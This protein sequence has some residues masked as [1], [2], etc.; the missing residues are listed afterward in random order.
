MWNFIEKIVYWF[1]NI[2]CKLAKKELTS[3]MLESMMQFAK[4][5][6][7]GISNTLLSYVIN[8]LVLIAMK[9]IDVSWDYFVGNIIAFIISVLWSF[10]WNNRFV[11]TVKEGETRSIWR[12]LL[13][14]Y[15]AY[16]F[17]GIVLSNVLSWMWVS[18]LEISKYV[19]PLLNLFISVPLNFLI[20]KL[21][22][23]KKNE[24]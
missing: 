24:S 13:R 23:F 19:A 16:G 8:I 20:N 2:I 18:V 6:I 11:F 17:T 5:G 15:I 14:T 12:T 4:F 7:I 22:A 10:F 21:W 9:P 3:S 1:L